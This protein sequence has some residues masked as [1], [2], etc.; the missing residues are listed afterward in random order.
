M[1]DRFTLAG[2]EQRDEAIECIRTAPPLSRVEVKGP[3]RKTNIDG[4]MWAMLADL[5]HQ[6]RWDGQLRTDEQWRLIVLDKFRRE[7]GR[8]MELVPNIDGN[9]W[10][11]IGDTSTA[12]YPDADIEHLIRIIRAF[13]SQHGVIWSE[14]APKDKRPVPPIEAY[15]EA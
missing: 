10:V 12:G 9:G 11:H 4:A 3:R 14:P 2:D 6:V 7:T 5:A 8:P 15:A 1:S 13:G